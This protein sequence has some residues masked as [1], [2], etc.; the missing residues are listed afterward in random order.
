MKN[1]LAAIAK[2]GTDA[3]KTADADTSRM[4]TRCDAQFQ[5]LKRLSASLT[6]QAA[7]AP[8][9]EITQLEQRTR[10]QCELVAEWTRLEARRPLENLW[11]QQLAADQELRA[12]LA[13]IRRKC[14]F[15]MAVLRRARRTAAAL[16]SLLSMQDPTYAPVSQ[17]SDYGQHVRRS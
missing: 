7:G 4:P 8:G 1:N 10:E 6:P 11:H 17:S 13:E 5:L 14:S 3:H 2:R 16:S 12:L 9:D 15:Q